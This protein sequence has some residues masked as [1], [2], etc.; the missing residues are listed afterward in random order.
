MKTI[1]CICIFLILL[2]SI[3]ACFAVTVDDFLESFNLE[4]VEIPG[5]NF[6]MLTTEVTQ[7]LF[8]EVMGE[9]HSEYKGEMFPVDSASWYDAIYFCNVLSEMFNLEPVYTVNGNTEVSTWNYEPLRGKVIKG[10]IGQNLESSGMRLPT[11]KEWWH[12]AYGGENT[13][14]SGSNLADEVAWHRQNA[15]WKSHEVAQKQP[16]KFGLYDM[17]GNVTEWVWDSTDNDPNGK[18]RIVCGGSWISYATD[19]KLNKLYYYPTKSRDPVI[20]FRF[21]CTIKADN[22]ADE[23]QVN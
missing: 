18:R 8:E 10:N 1:K 13:D 21:I 9:N 12:A 4:M 7:N 14:Y 19:T 20:G 15:D 6:K 5:A 23:T 17:S 2:L 22:N 16:N 11:I 3:P